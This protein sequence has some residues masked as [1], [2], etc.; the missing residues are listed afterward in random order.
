MFGQN[1]HMPTVVNLGDIAQ[2][3]ISVGNMRLRNI[4]RYPVYVYIS[5]NK[6]TLHWRKTLTKRLTNDSLTISLFSCTSYTRNMTEDLDQCYDVIVKLSKKGGQVSAWNVNKIASSYMY[7]YILRKRDNVCA[8]LKLLLDGW[9]T[10]RNERTTDHRWL[11]EWLGLAFKGV[12]LI[13]D[14]IFCMFLLDMLCWTNTP[15]TYRA[16]KYRKFQDFGC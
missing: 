5:G 9:W 3:S 11:A 6:Q 1:S 2:S 13:L 8:S 15:V 4:H 14:R 12:I 16:H 7:I 10:C